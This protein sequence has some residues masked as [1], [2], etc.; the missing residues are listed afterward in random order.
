[1]KAGEIDQATLEQYVLGGL[2]LREIRQIQ[3][4]VVTDPELRDRVEELQEAVAGMAYDEA[5]PPPTPLRDSVLSAMEEALEQDRASHSIPM[6]NSA[7]M[8]ED[9]A[10]WLNDP[11]NIRPTDALDFHLVELE[12]AE[13]RQTGLVWVKEGYPAEVHSDCVE[14]I[15]I[16]E[17]TCIVDVGGEQF[18]LSPGDV[19]TVPMHVE[20]SVRVTS[21]GW[22]KAII[23]RV[24]A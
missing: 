13:D 3:A 21:A 6:L 5:V 1:M 18:S 12:M 11:V 23:Q 10:E 9:F 14:R 4:M 20:H 8:R 24:A 22:C 2:S 15:L 16:I 7:S 19:F 17:G